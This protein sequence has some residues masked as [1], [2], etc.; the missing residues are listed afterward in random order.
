MLW[1][2]IKLL[3]ILAILGALALVAYAYIGPIFMPDDFDPPQV[4]IRLPVTLDTD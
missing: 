2:L 1:K 3:V 4:D